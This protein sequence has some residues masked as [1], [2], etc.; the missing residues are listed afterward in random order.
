MK[1]N[2]LATLLLGTLFTTLVLADAK[3]WH[4]VL[5][6]SLGPAWTNPGKTQTLYLQPELPETFA[7]NTLPLTF[8]EGDIFL[9]VQHRLKFDI[10][11]QLGLDLA[12]TTG[13]PLSG[14]IWQDADPNFNNLFYAYRI[15]HTHLAGKGKFIIDRYAPAQPYVSASLGVG[16]NRAYRYTNT[17]KLF[18]TLPE[19]PFATQI[20]TA[21]TY[22]LGV[23]LQRA[24]HQHWFLGL[25]YE[26]MDWGKT[27]LGPAVS[28]QTNNGPNLNHVYTNQLQFSLSYIA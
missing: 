20:T 12:G 19:P 13:I 7:A 4:Q 5:T 8:G 24:F 11:A 1:A 27:T 3:A 6:V 10:L 23:G 17:P 26:F 15:S 22:A 25:G 21:F 2:K 16:F 28:Q 18:E 14:D 9:G